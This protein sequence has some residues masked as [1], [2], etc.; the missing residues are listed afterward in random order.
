ML[1]QDCKEEEE[2]CK[3]LQNENN[4]FRNLSKHMQ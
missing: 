3:T 4:I 1:L 2:L